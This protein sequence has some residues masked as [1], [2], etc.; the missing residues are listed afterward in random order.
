[1]K[2]IVLIMCVL[3]LVLPQ[4][5]LGADIFKPQ[6]TYEEGLFNDIDKSDWF[7]GSVVGAYEYELSSGDGNGKYMPQGLVSIAEVITFADRLNM[8][9]NNVKDEPNAEK[10][11]KWYEPWIS[12]AEQSNIILEDEFK[13]RYE[14][15]A[16][17]GQV[18]YILGNALPFSLYENINTEVTNIHDMAN[19]DNYYNEVIMLYRAGVLTGKDGYGNFAP[20]ENITRAEM[21]AVIYRIANSDARI[22]IDVKKADSSAFSGEYDA[23][24][25]S[26]IASEAV[27]LVAVYDKKG[28][29]T[30]TGSGF[31]IDKNGTAVTNYHVIK[32]AASAQIM[33]VDGNNYDVDTVL[34]YSEQRDIAILNIKGDNFPYVEVGNSANIKNGQ[35]IYCIGSPLGLDNTISEGLISNTSRTID[36]SEYIQISA[37]ISPGSSGGAVFNDA[38]QVIG[39]TSASA[40]AGQ[41]INLVIP[42]NSIYD[43][44]WNVNAS[45]SDIFGGN[46]KRSAVIGY[47]S[48][49][50]NVPDYT[51][52][53]GAVLQDKQEDENYW[54]YIYSLDTDQVNAYIGYLVESGYSIARRQIDSTAQRYIYYLSDGKN[55][56]AVEMS[57]PS[58]VVYV[59]IQKAK[60]SEGSENTTSA[61]FYNNTKIPTYTYVC[62]RRCIGTQKTDNGTAYRYSYNS[63]EM[64]V[65]ISY[66]GRYGWVMDRVTRGSN[67]ITTIMENNG[68][69]VYISYAFIYG[70]VWVTV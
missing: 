62:G 10:N 52:V 15:P 64:M 24:Q 60:S 40:T 68:Q 19:T 67:H 43:I 31:F 49:N 5:V 55:I 50:K 17:R 58:N 34:G 45:L 14:K 21:A 57:V 1:M 6:R 27:F 33:T 25:I 66:L 36:G 46:V 4:S 20:T 7:Y 39:I 63:A 13:G 23:E 9:Y 12:Y 32:G 56:V 38:A 69:R 44:D 41:N 48:E 30:G 11:E 3:C 54:Y 2:K 59:A 26:E 28:E 47:Y 8:R 18:A 65:Y 53:T 22:K 61:E 51:S 16:T 70:E 35:K 42:I 29:L 37:P